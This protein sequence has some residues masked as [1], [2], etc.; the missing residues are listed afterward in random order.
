MNCDICNKREHERSIQEQCWSDEEL[1][2]VIKVMDTTATE[3]RGA[4]NV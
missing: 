4:R 3:I 1:K 2:E